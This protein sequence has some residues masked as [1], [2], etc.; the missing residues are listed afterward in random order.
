MII[1]IWFSTYLHG[2]AGMA[3]TKHKK[4]QWYKD[5]QTRLQFPNLN[6]K[7]NK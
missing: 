7:Q 6:N 2:N 5:K 3:P 1:E 4:S